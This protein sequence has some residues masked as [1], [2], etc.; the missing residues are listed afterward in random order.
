LKTLF[1]VISAIGNDYG[2]FSYAQ[3]LSQLMD[4]IHSIRTRSPCSDIW[5]YDAS[6]DPL[7]DHDSALLSNH[8]GR[9]SLLYD[10]KYINFLKYKS[11]DPSPN[12]FEKK[13]VGEIQCVVRFLSDLKQSNLQYSRVFKL[14]GRYKLSDNFIPEHY[15][16]RQ[17]LVVLRPKEDWYGEHVYTLR[18]WSFCYSNFDSIIE[19]F[20]QI[21][22]HTYKTVTDTKRLEIIEFTFTK[23]LEQ[24]QIPIHIVNK[25]GVTGLMGLVGETVNE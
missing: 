25:I 7:P 10:D 11:L 17:G 19:L 1:V 2:A 14:S 15:D 5:L 3:R 16:D 4:T 22:T 21:Q 8:V 20:T 18:L 24:L 9:L 12:K 23:F 13:T 6:E